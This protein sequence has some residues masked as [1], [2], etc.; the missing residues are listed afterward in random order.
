MMAGGKVPAGDNPHHSDKELT[1][2]L[3]SR[4]LKTLKRRDQKAQTL[5]SFSQEAADLRAPGKTEMPGEPSKP[6]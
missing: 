5:L 2:I 1:D 6:I 4:F 3:E